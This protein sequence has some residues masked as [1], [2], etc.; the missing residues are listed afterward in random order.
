MLLSAVLLQVTSAIAWGKI[1]GTL[2]AAI[3]ALAAAWGISK[4]GK[5]AMD[6]IAR[7]PE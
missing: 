4:I 3:A 6:A 7:Q 5:S 1:A 2:G